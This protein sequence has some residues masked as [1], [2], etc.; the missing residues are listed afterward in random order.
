VLSEYLPALQN[1]GLYMVE[2]WHTAFGQYPVRLIGFQ[3][4]TDAE[5]REIIKGAGWQ[6]SKEKLLNY[7]RDYEE[8]LVEAKN[9]FQF[10]VPGENS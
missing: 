8:R 9:V 6:E 2:G 4:N 7:V 5:L 3:A 1:L 10:F